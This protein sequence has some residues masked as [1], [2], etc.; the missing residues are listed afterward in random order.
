MLLFVIRHGDPIYSPDSLTPQGKLQA[1]ALAKRFA[2]HGLDKIY[3]SPM[4]RAQETARPTSEMLNIPIQ[5]EDWASEDLAWSEFTVKYSGDYTHW[6]FFRQNT[7]FHQN[8]DE[9]LGN[10]NWKEAKSVQEIKDLPH[11]YDRL[12]KASDDFLERLGYRREGIGIYKILKPSEERVAL[13]CHQGVSL[14]L[15]PYM[16]GIPPHLFWSA[17]DVNHTGV[18]VFEFRNNPNGLTSPKC[19]SLSDCSHLLNEGLPYKFQNVIDL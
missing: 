9:L 15:F 10:G 18:S 5:I 8:G 3:A 7:E 17:F 19:I 12:E 13:F 11:C 2:I 16:L 14:L 6:I 1:Q 4:I